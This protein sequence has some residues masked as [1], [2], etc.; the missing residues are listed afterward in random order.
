MRVI[1]LQTYEEWK[2]LL[3]DFSEYNWVVP[4]YIWELSEQID[5]GKRVLSLM[6][7]IGSCMD[8]PN[9]CVGMQ[10]LWLDASNDRIFGSFLFGQLQFKLQAT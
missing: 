4:D 5:L 1:F 6:K 7:I 3:P 9:I 10:L 2:D 8:P